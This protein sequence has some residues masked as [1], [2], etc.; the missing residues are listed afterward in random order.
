ML[1]INAIYHIYT[2]PLFSNKLIPR[3]RVSQTFLSLTNFIEKNNNIYDIRRVYYENI[4]WA[5]SL[6]W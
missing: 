5:R 2:L 4:L 6:V 3:I 1:A